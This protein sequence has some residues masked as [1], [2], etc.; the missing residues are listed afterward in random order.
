MQYGLIGEKLGHSFSAEIHQKLKS[1]PY[2]LVELARDEIGA[3]LETKD[4]CAINV[5]I[6]YKTTVIPYLSHISKRAKEIGAVNTIV[7]RRGELWGYNTDFYGLQSL[8][9]HAGI[10]LQNKKVAILGTGGTSKTAHAVAHFLGAG[11]ILTVSRTVGEGVITYTDLT[12]DHID[13]DVLIN[14]TPVGMYPNTEATPVDIS[15]FSNL[16]GVIDAIYNPLRT[17][18]ILDA[19]KRGI[20]AEG[21]LYMLVAQAVR[22]SELFLDTVYEGETTEHIYLEL[23]NKTENIVLSGMPGAGKSTV[24]KLLAKETKRAFFDLDEEIVRVA[25]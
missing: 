13:V 24:G 3:F 8:I 25:G 20:P 5:T 18:L 19:K 1:N 22:A 16:S 6:P 14:T 15:V 2:T 4:F 11:Q 12:A 17:K 7:N 9:E 21:G 10:T 23:L